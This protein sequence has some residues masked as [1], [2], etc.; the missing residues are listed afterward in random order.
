MSL[1]TTLQRLVHILDEAEIPYMLSG[2]VVSSYYGINRSTQDMDLVIAPN[3]PS[4]HRFCADASNASF[5]VSHRNAMDALRSRA[6]FNVIDM[7]TA[8]K[9]DLII[10]KDRPF[11]ISEFKR[12]I[13][14]EILGMPLWI[15]SIEDSI[16]S[17]LEWAKDSGSTRQLDDVAGMFRVGTET[18]DG[19]YLKKWAAELGV[20]DSLSQFL[21]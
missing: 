19:D 6:Q 16:L 5:Y 2:S 17:K 10:R 7:S 21:A 8:W 11:S 15:A 1:K 14:R 9:A 4:L 12:R 20:A 13:R 18:Q 3:E